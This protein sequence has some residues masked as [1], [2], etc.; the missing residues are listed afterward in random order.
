MKI[1]DFGIS[2]KVLNRTRRTDMLTITGTLF[3]RAPEMFEGGG[4]DERVDLWALGA[5]IYKLM[6][7]RTPFESTYHSET[8]NNILRGEFSFPP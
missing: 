5:T 4:Y 3:Y 7:G 8:I 6:V 2:R 1:I